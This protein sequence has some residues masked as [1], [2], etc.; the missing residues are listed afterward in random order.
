MAGI[1]KLRFI[2]LGLESS[3]GT[4]VPATAIWYGKG[5]MSDDRTIVYPDDNV[6]YLVDVDRSY[7]SY[8]LAGID[9][10]ENDATFE[11]IG[12][13]LSAS[14]LD[15][16]SGAANG[17]TSNA[18][19]YAYVVPATSQ[20]TTKAYTIE[21]GDDYQ[22]YEAEY[23]FCQ[24]WSLK[25]APKE[26]VKIASKW[27]GRQM[28]KSTKTT[29]TLQPV[30]TILFQKGKIYA[31]AVGGTIGSTQLTNTWLGFEMNYD[32]GIKEVPSGDGNLYF[33]FTKCT[34]P[35][36]TGSFTFE[37][38]ASGVAE[39][40]DFVAQTAKKIRMEFLG[41][42]TGY[43]GSGGTFSTRALRIDLC[44]RIDKVDKLASVNG[45]DIL[46]VSW[47]ARYNATAALTAEITVCNLLTALV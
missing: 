25:G 12:Y 31:D 33:S 24:S 14:V 39:Y 22:E 20:P 4:S 46:K 43:T 18:K 29:L 15:V 44:A 47:S 3:K 19:K 34:G 5:G 11:Q 26:A 35:K 10:D 9:F 38:D 13:P 6:G 28:A 45:N 8:L 2:Q 36:I 41:S 27:L 23:C 7:V 32:S 37:H 42:A 30:E 21:C 17:G 1:E 40:D 16:V